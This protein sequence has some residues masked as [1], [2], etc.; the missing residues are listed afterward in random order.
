M[1]EA[2][3]K[4]RF[5]TMIWFTIGWLYIVQLLGISIREISPLWP[6]MS[7]WRRWPRPGSCLWSEYFHF[8]GS[9]CAFL[10]LNSGS[11]SGSQDSLDL[12][13]D[14]NWVKASILISNSPFPKTFFQGREIIIEELRIISCILYFVKFGPTCQHTLW[15]V[16]WV[17][18]VWQSIGESKIYLYSV[19]Q[20]PKK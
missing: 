7:W 19:W 8:N 17:K 9:F 12:P 18:L 3:V 1:K 16:N 11:A 5:D 13:E 2:W 4:C 14:A 6:H 10:S 15:T 20:T